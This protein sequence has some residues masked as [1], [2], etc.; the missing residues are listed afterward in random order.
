MLIAIKLKKHFFYF[1]FGFP[2]NKPW[3][4]SIHLACEGFAFCFHPGVYGNILFRFHIG[5]L[6]IWNY[7]EWWKKEARQSFG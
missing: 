3:K 5:S 6:D 2:K 1:T 4:V 7:E